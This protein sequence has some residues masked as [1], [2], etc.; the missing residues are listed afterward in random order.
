MH[1]L[2]HAGTDDTAGI[3]PAQTANAGQILTRE[4]ELKT[5]SC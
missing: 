2:P 4:K 1:A 3:Q 5:V